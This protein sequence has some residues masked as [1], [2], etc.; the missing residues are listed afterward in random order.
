MYIT[1]LLRRNE[2][3]YHTVHSFK[4]VY[5][6]VGFSIFKEL[7][8]HYHNLRT[9]SIPLKE[10]LNPLLNPRQSLIY[11][12]SLWIYLFWKWNH[13]LSDLLCLT[14]FNAVIF[15]RFTDV[16]VKSD[17]LSK[18]KNIGKVLLLF[19]LMSNLVKLFNNT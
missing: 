9:F 11:F 16:V 8:S 1:V 5:F 18:P 12:L 17:T 14:S 13:S 2:C 4:S 19:I 7:C 15:S 10:V 6:L 3:I